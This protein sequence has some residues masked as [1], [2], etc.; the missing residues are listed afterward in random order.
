MS[1][2]VIPP[3]TEE[4]AG[5]PS[6]RREEEAAPRIHVLWGRL[7]I[8]ALA[9]LASFAVGRLTA[10]DESRGALEQ[11]RADVAEAR[12]Q[13]SEARADVES[14][15]RQL[16]ER[17]SPTPSPSPTGDGEAAATNPAAQ[18]ETYVVRAGDTLQSIAFEF[19][20]DASLADVIA[21]AND[22]TAPS[23]LRPGLELVIP[24]RPEL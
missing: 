22:I 13:L 23:Q 14:L 11:T 16:A 1:Q 21:E 17:A 8:L 12:S 15:Q 7:A 18:D 5:E 4:E 19:Y 6:L 24:A 3:P 10:P 20:E 9:L 2:G